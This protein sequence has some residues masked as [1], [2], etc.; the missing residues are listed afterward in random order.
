MLL[1]LLLP[2]LWLPLTLLLLLVLLPSTSLVLQ[3]LLMLVAGLLLV[4]LSTVSHHMLLLLLLHHAIRLLLL[5]LP[6]ASSCT[7]LVPM[8]SRLLRPCLLHAGTCSTACISSGQLLC[9]Q[10][11]GLQRLL[12]QL[13]LPLQLL[14]VLCRLHL[15]PHAHG[16]VYFWCQLLLAR[17]QGFQPGLQLT[18]T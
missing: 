14:L 16:M 9:V 11:L 4:I 15:V 8:S 12:L 10:L 2:V 7:L 18:D 5:L 3:L 1:P 13:R 6:V 17:G